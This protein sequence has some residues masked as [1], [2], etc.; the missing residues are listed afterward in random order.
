MSA[1]RLS[2]ERFTLEPADRRLRHDGR[3]IDLNNRYFDA[4]LLLVRRPGALVSKAEFFEEVWRGVPVTDEALTQC[5]RTLRRL[6]GDDAAN[7][8]FIETVPK[9]GYRLMVAVDASE[10]DQA[11]DALDLLRAV[12]L[13]AG[14]GTMGAG[15][16][17]LV[18]G[19]AYGMLV[20]SQPLGAGTGSASIVVLVLWL[21][22]AAALLGGAGV[23]VGLALADMTHDR[24]ML[25]VGGAA[26]G[27]AVGAIAKLLGLDAFNLLLGQAPGDITGPFEGLTLGAVVGLAAWLAERDGTSVR[28]MLALTLLT[29]LVGGALIAV[30]GGRL[31]GG[32]LDNLARMLPASRISMAGVGGWFS[33][34][35]FGT[36]SRIVTSGLEAALFASSICFARSRLPVRA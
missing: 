28:R 24:R 8:R 34:P 27:L 20:A 31:M 21:T 16:A 26:G 9:H 35:H 14:A 3:V 32:S 36:I 22:M 12:L 30:A 11:Q 33:E 2:F 25:V 7:P 19:L 4:L 23:S 6:L 18:G 13:R 29:G 1:Q 15:V 5:I 17:G 10:P